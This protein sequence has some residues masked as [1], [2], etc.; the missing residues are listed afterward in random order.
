M[1][2]F[3]RPRVETYYNRPTLA[4]PGAILAAAHLFRFL[5]WH[6]ETLC[7]IAAPTAVRQD[8]WDAQ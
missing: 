3:L 4:S 1:F 6:S 5:Y 2:T 8:G 7:R